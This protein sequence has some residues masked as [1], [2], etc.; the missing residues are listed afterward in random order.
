M[1]SHKSEFVSTVSHDLRA[2]LILMRGYAKMLPMVGE[3]NEQQREFV[4]KILASVERMS[5]LVDDLL[6]LGRIETGIG[7]HLTTVPL[8]EMLQDVVSSFRPQAVNKQIVLEVELAE[9]LAPVEADPM[10]MRQA[11]A[12]LV[13]N[14]IKYTP[15]GGRV[16]LH[17]I[18]R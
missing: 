17:E 5:K 11:I 7:L 4:E 13:D 10:L 6:D 15:A 9:G 12:N 18:G 16:M 1:D 14:A 3:V 8:E 2:P